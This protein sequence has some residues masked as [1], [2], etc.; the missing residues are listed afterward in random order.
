MRFKLIVLHLTMLALFSACGGLD[1]QP[2][3]L[4]RG[5]DIERGR[6]VVEIMGC[7][8]C[9]TPGYMGSSTRLP[10][11]EWLVGGTLGFH[12][13]WGTA[14]PSN[15]RLMLNGMSEDDWLVIARKMRQSSPMSWV[16]L[17]KAT[18][19]DLRA[20]YRF[21]KYLGPKGLP[22]PARLSAGVTPTTDYIDFPEPH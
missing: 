2:A 21:V 17:P 18:E 5:P 19:Q 6:Y 12:G 8:D 9:H 16:R 7:N 11:G 22:A 4:E 14:Y 1:Q 3:K 15:L 10:E 13:S 20:I